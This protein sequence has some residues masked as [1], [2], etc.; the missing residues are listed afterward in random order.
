MAE[1]YGRWQVIGKSDRPN[2]VLARCRCGAKKDVNVYNLRS[3]RSTQCRGCATSSLMTR[4]GMTD[5]PEH[6]SWRDM[7]G[8]RNCVDAWNDFEAFFRDMG[9]KPPGTM[10]HCA[11]PDKPYGPG[12]AEWLGEGE[13]RSICAARASAKAAKKGGHMGPT[14]RSLLEVLGRINRPMRTPVLAG[15]AGVSTSAA[16]D[17]LLRLKDRREVVRIAPGV[18]VRVDS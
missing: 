8:R 1:T 5:T 13:A 6:R 7:H 12:N 2:S 14:Q 3:G 11:N 15:L 18:W 4:H 17:S 16:Y 10:L 9:P